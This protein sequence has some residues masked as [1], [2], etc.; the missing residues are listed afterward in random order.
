MGL[1]RIERGLERLVEGT[2][3][4]V[5]RS[6]LQP[7]EIGRRLT[8]EMDLRRQVGVNG[9]VAPNFYS[10]VLAQ[11]DSDRFASYMD[12]LKR[13]LVETLRDHGR[14]ERYTFLGPVTVDISVDS[15][16]TAG[17]FL[18][19]GSVKEQP[20]GGPMGALVLADG[21]RIELSDHVV[22]IGRLPE[23]DI[24]L[25]DSNVSRKHAEVKRHGN[26]FV[27]VDLG[28]TNGTKVNGTWVNGERRLHD[29]DEI[30]IAATSIRFEGS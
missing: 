29:G 30:L 24:A 13:E 5:F 10:I 7:V 22:T 26:D 15:K 9:I 18:I 2:F 27:V 3:A 23:C 17:R 1:Q 6:G 11:S 28:S 8:R 12:A 21:R 20:G 19:T 25:V 14:N 16:M 4:K